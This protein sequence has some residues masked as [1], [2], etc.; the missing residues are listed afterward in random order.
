MLDQR[1]FAGALR[2]GHHVHPLQ[3]HRVHS[4]LGRDRYLLL[5]VFTVAESLHRVPD[6]TP[7]QWFPEGEKGPFVNAGLE[8]WLKNI[9]DW[10][11]EGTN[12]PWASLS[13]VMRR[14]R[15]MKISSIN[16]VVDVISD[17]TITVSDMPEPINLDEVRRRESGNV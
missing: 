11:A 3:L 12:E 2:G 13:C 10:R 7:T 8:R 16:Q 14:V 5:S 4:L 17:D 15:R 6:P 9:Q 1:V